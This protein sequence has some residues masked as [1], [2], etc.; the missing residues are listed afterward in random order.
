MTIT[1]N[2][3]SIEKAQSSSAEKKHKRVRC[4]YPFYRMNVYE[5]TELKPCCDAWFKNPLGDLLDSDVDDNWNND[6]FQK[7]RAEMY[8]G[9]NPEKYC[10]METCPILKSGE[11]YDLDENKLNVDDKI[12]DE[13]RE[14]KTE[15]DNGP[16]FIELCNDFKCNY[17]C[18]MCSSWQRGE[19]PGG[20]AAEII[21]KLESRFDK[22]HHIV[23]LSSGEVFA[24]PKLL[25]YLENLDATKYPNL[26]FS[27]ITNG[28][29]VTEKRWA[30]L[31]HLNIYSMNISLDAARADTYAEVRVNG[32]WDKIL[33]QIRYLI[34]RRDAGDFELF[35]LNMTVMRQNHDQLVEFAHLAREL[36]VDSIYYQWLHSYPEFSIADPADWK[37][38][39]LMEDQLADPVM[40]D[41]RI[42]NDQLKDWWKWLPV[43]ISEPENVEEARK[44]VVHEYICQ[45]VSAITDNKDRRTIMKMWARWVKQHGDSSESFKNWCIWIISSGR[46]VEDNFEHVDFVL[47]LYHHV[48]RNERYSDKDIWHWERECWKNGRV[49]V[50]KEFFK[51]ED[52]AEFHK[53]A[54]PE[55]P[56]LKPFDW[57][58][59][60]NYESKVE[61]FKDWLRDIRDT[62]RSKR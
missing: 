8:E 33:D 4:I 29:L 10:R 36:K 15:L 25:D 7:V 38:L 1:E 51:T 52:F 19:G 22:V 9:G 23:M 46:I 37:A 31:S 56:D 6:A 43:S 44:F 12:I 55:D 60:L 41:E 14:G 61:E 62:V 53:S 20:D 42:D 49:S 13:V 45:V 39:Q 21:K 26:R 48:I 57:S 18:V 30:Q 40:N 16:H 50:L 59:Y 5:K 11:W 2:D 54:F 24:R 47:N 32:K 28:S 17:K 35:F 34:E 3:T 27:F 58:E